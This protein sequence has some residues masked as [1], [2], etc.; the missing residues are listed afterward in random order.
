MGL[1]D[2][3]AGRRARFVSRGTRHGNVNPVG[4][5]KL[6]DKQL[7]LARA[8]AIAIEKQADAVVNGLLAGGG[9]VCE[10]CGNWIWLRNADSDDANVLSCIDRTACAERIIEHQAKR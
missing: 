2:V 8:A 1:A 5:D 6:S 3:I 10:R 4:V 9:V 7:A